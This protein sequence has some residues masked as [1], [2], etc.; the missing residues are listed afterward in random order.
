MIED[1]CLMMIE[2]GQDQ[3]IQE[4]ILIQEGAGPHPVIDLDVSTL[5]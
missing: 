3:S 5:T 2:P 1:A 4:G